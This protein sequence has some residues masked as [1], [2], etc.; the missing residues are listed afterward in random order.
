MAMMDDRTVQR[1]LQAA[2]YYKDIID[3]DY[4]KNSKIAAREQAKKRGHNYSSSWTDDRVRAAAEQAIMADAGFYTLSIDGLVGSGT[5][6]ALEKWQDFITFK[7]KPLPA[8][9]IAHLAPA[10]AKTL[11]PR[12]ADLIKFY[13]GVGKNQTMLQSPYLLYLDW[14]LSETVKRFS[15]HEKVHDAALR[16]MKRVLDYY[17]T[18]EIHKLGL[19][20]FGG[21]L[22][23]RK[24]RNGTAWSTHAWG[25]A[26]D[27]DADRNPLRATSS[28]AMMA[29]AP[30]AKFLDLWEEEGFVSLGRASNF[31]W[32]HVQAARL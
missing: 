22:A 21:C 19:D 27:W 4:G 18:G 17:G 10:T 11:W 6:V 1:A 2:G 5:Q 28:T 30:Y 13:G 29:T 15:I 16:V 3:G 23:V 12:Q 31:D 8:E 32:M 9:D 24:M 7:R 20:Q 26:M 14:S 25:I